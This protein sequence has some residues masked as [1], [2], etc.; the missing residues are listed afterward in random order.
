[1]GG[2]R[3]RT[4]RPVWNTAAYYEEYANGNATG[5]MTIDWGQSNHQSATL[6]G[7]C[8]FTFTPP[9]GSCVLKIKC[10]NFGAHTPT[11]PVTVLWQSGTE[12]TWT[13]AGTDICV[14]YYDG[15][16]YYGGALL[17]CS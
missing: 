8:V 17:D 13:A 15:T 7:N 9:N 16:N 2:Y 11:W 1:M 3:T 6:T 12:P 10:I 5:T 14:F 4:K